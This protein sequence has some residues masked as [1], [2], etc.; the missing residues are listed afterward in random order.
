MQCEE[1]AE[2]RVDSKATM[3]NDFPWEGQLRVEIPIEPEVL[4]HGGEM[5]MIIEGRGKKLKIAGFGFPDPNSP[6]GAK[7]ERSPAAGH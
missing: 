1:G 4:A 6:V 3:P 7:H 2:M 5:T